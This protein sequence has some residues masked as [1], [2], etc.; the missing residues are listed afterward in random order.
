MHPNIVRK[1]WR[2]E[3]W[4]GRI[5][6]LQNLQYQDVSKRE[7]YERATEILELVGLQEHMN[8]YAQ[9]PLL[10]GGQLQR[11]AIARSLLANPR[12]LLMDE[13]FGALDIRT[14]LRMQ[15]MILNIWL[16]LS[17]KDSS[18]TII[19]ITHDVSEAIYLSDEI[20][21]MKSKPGRFI[22]KIPIGI[23]Y[24]QRNKELKRTQKFRDLISE[25][26][27]LI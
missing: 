11:V 12:I 17:Q 3:F 15:D 27:D 19:F 18:T 8:K 13:P 2:F 20:Y 1:Y 26:E 4:C 14:R 16:K 9:Y 10:S 5:S 7:R 24:P 25:I 22:K 21:I 23:P 6:L